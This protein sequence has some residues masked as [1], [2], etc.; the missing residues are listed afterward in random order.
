MCGR[1]CVS[2]R[3]RVCGCQGACESRARIG[4]SI[5][6]AGLRLE[7]AC[8][9]TLALGV[10][11]KSSQ[12]TVCGRAAWQ[13]TERPTLWLHRPRLLERANR[14]CARPAEGF[15]SFARRTVR[16]PVREL[17]RLART[18]RFYQVQRDRRY[19]SHQVLARLAGRRSP[20][21]VAWSWPLKNWQWSR[22]NRPLPPLGQP[23]EPNAPSN[24]PR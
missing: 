5:G 8:K 10:Y 12:R 7:G 15:A 21:R 22:R 16:R 14:R 13:H 1:S 23:Q 19:S 2:R 9:Q 17:A 4:T 6:P 11:E 3:G 20:T 24:S 18:P